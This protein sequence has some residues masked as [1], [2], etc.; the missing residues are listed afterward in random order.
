MLFFGKLNLYQKKSRY[1]SHLPCDPLKLERDLTAWRGIPAASI[2]EAF[3]VFKQ[4]SFHLSSGLVDTAPD[5][6]G[7]KVFEESLDKRIFVRSS[8]TA[9]CWGISEIAMFLIQA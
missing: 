7:L 4:A 1:L 2:L 3:D 9:H 5:L 8:L 6:T